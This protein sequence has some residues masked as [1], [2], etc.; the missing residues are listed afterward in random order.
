LGAQKYTLIFYPAKK[1]GKMIQDPGAKYGIKILVLTSGQALDTDSAER[2]G[3]FSLK[4]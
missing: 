3:E 2:G 4:N 1:L